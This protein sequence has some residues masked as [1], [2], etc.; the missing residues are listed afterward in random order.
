MDALENGE[1]SPPPH[2]SFE[3]KSSSARFTK[4]STNAEDDGRVA[5]VGRDA[6]PYKRGGCCGKRTPSLM[7]VLA[8]TFFKTFLASAVL[9]LVQDL[10]LFVSPQLLR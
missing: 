1:D 2:L 5:L 8:K 7:R 9:K 10:L 3:L 6:T 4:L